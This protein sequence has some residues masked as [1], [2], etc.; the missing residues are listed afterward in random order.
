MSTRRLRL[1]AWHPH[2]DRTPPLMI[3]FR[4]DPPARMSASSP[5]MAEKAVDRPLRPEGIQIS[6]H[7]GD[8]ER[9]LQ[10]LP[11]PVAWPLLHN[12]LPRGGL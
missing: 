11:G 2:H 1:M 7:S 5:A 12:D 3:V 4:R 10:R 9:H 6:V 8:D